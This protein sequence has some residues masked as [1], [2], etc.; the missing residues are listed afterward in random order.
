[1]YSISV[2]T[3][4]IDKI[5]LILTNDMS[6]WWC[7][8][9]DTCSIMQWRTNSQSMSC[10]WP[11]KAPAACFASQRYVA[12]QFDSCCTYWTLREFD[13]ALDDLICFSAQ[14]VLRFGYK[15]WVNP[16][17]AEL[18][19]WNHWSRSRAESGEGGESPRCGEVW[20]GPGEG[21]GCP[22]ERSG[23]GVAL[24]WVMVL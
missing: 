10:Q 20:R 13:V 5:W 23:D 11:W 24:V 3:I 16:W 17:E 9:I 4:F 1:M 15:R 18:R 14:E 22:C 7:I 19:H 21:R 6:E 8:Y 2:R 12:I